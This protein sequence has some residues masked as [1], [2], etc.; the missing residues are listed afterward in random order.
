[1]P[2]KLELVLSA[3]DETKRGWD[4]AIRT[5]KTAQGQMGDPSGVKLAGAP[6]AASAKASIALGMEKKKLKT[7]TK[8]LSV[9]NS[10]KKSRSI[11]DNYLNW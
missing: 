7:L 9:L 11:L 10:I 3:A 5:A 4:Q 6:G 1:M 8:I 2:E